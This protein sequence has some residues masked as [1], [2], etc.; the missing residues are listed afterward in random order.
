L[1]VNAAASKKVPSAP[2][3]RAGPPEATVAQA[4]SLIR[5]HGGRSTA[6]RRVVIEALIEAQGELRDA[7]Q[8]VAAVQGRYPSIND[9]T[10]YRTLDLLEHLGLARHVHL[11]HGPSQ[12]YLSD[13]RRRWYLTCT[14][15]GRAVETDSAVF[16]SLTADVA[17][18][19]GFVIDPG[20]FAVTGICAAC[21]RDDRY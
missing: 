4:M 20:H 18:R 9:S 19:T 11:G 12:W 7:D 6:S 5:A 10:V 1:T 17:S 3:G 15:C 14:R 16:D 8:I 2:A 21:R 13:E